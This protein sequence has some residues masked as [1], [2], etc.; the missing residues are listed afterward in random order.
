[1][2]NWKVIGI[3]GGIGAGKSLL[4]KI[5][6]AAGFPVFSADQIAK[7]IIAKGTPGWQEIVDT[8]GK[9]ILG[10]DGEI[11]RALLRERIAKN[12]A[13]RLQLDAITHPKIQKRSAELFAEAAQQGHSL[14]FY[15]APLLFEAKSDKKMDAVICVHAPDEVR[16]KRTM[17]RDGS[18]RDQVEKL[19]NSQMS[20]AEKIKRSDFALL[21]DGDTAQFKASA[22]ELLEQLKKKYQA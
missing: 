11:Q 15:E 13:D 2:K 18:Q 12:P 16:I 17:A 21:N 6:A 20:Q 3:T 1:M 4:A 22:L 5:Y 7:E 8:F 9:E 10:K 19:L 14:L